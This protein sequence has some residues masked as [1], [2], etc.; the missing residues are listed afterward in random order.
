MAVPWIC[1]WQLLLLLVCCSSWGHTEAPSFQPGILYQYDYALDLTIEHISQPSMPASRLQGRALVEIYVLWRHKAQPDEQ[2]LHVQIQDFAIHD[3]SMQKNSNGSAEEKHHKDPANS[4]NMGRPILF[5]WKSG[6]VLGMYSA[7]EDNSRILDIKRGLISLFQ[8]QPL[9]GIYT[10]E[11]VSGRCRVTYDTSKTSIKKTKDLHSC[12]NSPFGFTADHK[13]FGVSQNFTNKAVMSLNNSVIQ[14]VIA[15][16]SH[17]VSLRVKSRLGTRIA[18]RQQMVFKSSS[19]GPAEIHEENMLNILKVL[20]EQFQKTAITCHPLRRTEVSPTFK[21]YMK[22]TKKPILKVNVSKATTTKHFHTFVKMMRDA[23]KRDV[24]Q[25]LQQA[26]RD[27]VLFYIDAAVASQ[28]LPALE[29]L[30][31]FLDFSKKKQI[32]L[33]EKFLYSAAFAP[34]PST[35]LLNLVLDKLNGR[36]S[37]PMIMETGLIIAGAIVGKLCKLKLCDTKDVEFAKQTLIK[38]LTRAEDESDIKI[39]LLALKNAQLP[40][41]IPLLLQYAEDSSAV[42]S[43]AAL[44]ALQGFPAQQ[45]ATKDVKETLRIIFHQAEQKYDKTSRLMAAEMLLAADSLG[46]DLINI[47]SNLNTMDK[48]ASKLL[49]SKVQDRLSSKQTIKKIGKK[50]LNETLLHNYDILSRLGKSTT[51]FGPLAATSDTLSSFGLELLFSESGLMKMSTSDI[52]LHHHNQHIRAM[53]VSVESQ[54]LESLIGDG[55]AEEESDVDA[56]VGMSAILFDVQLRPV[57]FFKGY[58][59]LMSKVFASSGEPTSVVKGNVLL[60]DHLQWLPMQSGL[61]AFIE[62]Q[63]GLGLEILANIDVSIWEQESKTSI[64]TKSG[65]VLEYNTE[66]DSGF[67]QV[68]LKGQ[69]DAEITLGFDSVMKF[70]GFPI[71]MCLQLRQD[72]LPYR[73]KYTVMESLPEKNITRTVR[74]GRKSTIWGRDFPL[75]HANSE[76]CKSLLSDTE[77]IHE[78]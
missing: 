23:K 55:A 20:P 7:G 77:H 45:L 42:V 62:Y 60:I 1:Y 12:T 41:T 17:M 5:H 50:L 29:A 26:S 19:P 11:D 33:H 38:G 68:S 10:E 25:L 74:K 56:S 54:G 61:Q 16:E 72:N 48:E 57:V 63:G 46:T 35:D 24:L 58:M 32:D 2:L 30:S 75:H 9:Y 27:M 66:V 36:I 49:L 67:F 4:G 31:E 13:V 6:K 34:H 44:S 70:T 14:M 37:E 28:S 47:L 3:L 59:D 65:L 73:E 39:F 71:L 76:M 15:E 40:E 51:F 64:N 18:S 22:T 8:F 21:N 78:T 43:N 53:Q 69:T 52:S